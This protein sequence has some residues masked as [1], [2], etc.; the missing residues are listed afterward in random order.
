MMVSRRGRGRILAAAVAGGALAAAGT[1]ITTGP[2]QSAAVAGDCAAPFPVAEVAKGDAVTGKTVASGTTPDPFTGTVLGV[3]E[4]GIAPGLDM[5]MAELTSPAVDDHG[6]WQGMSGS[7][8]YAQD[9]RLIGAVAYGLSYGESP[10][11]GITP[12]E[13]MDDYLS[14]QTAAARIQ[15]SPRTAR[16]I[17]SQTD[18]SR[19]QASEGFRRLPM[20]VLATGAGT[21]PRD[22]TRKQRKYLVKAAPGAAGSAEV[23]ADAIEAGGNLAA[24][25]SYGDLTMSGVGTVTS[26]CNDEVVGFG[27]PMTF[28]GKT[29]MG[30]SPA[31]AIYVHSDGVSPGFKVANV[32]APVGT[33]TNDRLTGISGNLGGAPEGTDVHSAVTFDTRSRALDSESFV[34]QWNADLVFS[35]TL[36]NHD[37]VV[38]AITSGSSVVSYR[39]TGTDAGGR[40]FSVVLDDRYQSDYDISF[41]ALWDP[42]DITWVLSGM[43]GVTVQDVSLTS[44]VSED[45][46]TYQ[47]RQLQVR[48]GGAWRTVSRRDAIKVGAGEVLR[49][50]AKLVSGDGSRY[51]RLDT[52][53]PRKA[54]GSGGFL[55]VSGGGWMWSDFYGAQTPQE[56]NKAVR[57]GAR[58][59]EVQAR[60]SFSK[61]GVADK[62]VTSAP[63]P[64][65]V[66]GSRYAELRITR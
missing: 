7:P 43:S 12:F 27:H 55:E 1:T 9:G 26:V 17:A 61:R 15:V 33:I 41:E 63:Q 24:S 51:V 38:D 49:L 34:K 57:A 58:N 42:A 2:A 8:V 44:A 64:R 36:A 4:D 52:R 62:T 32:G 13:E 50:R 16:S 3:L 45:S 53:V 66:Y 46:A 10:V 30:L 22:L 65:V 35:Q 56:L 28:G 54:A 48:R 29:S 47:V 14:G 19:E 11:A 18:V 23:A 37:R 21:I 25:I 31:D 5:V 40:A 39:A 20:P 60:F 59:D 6:I